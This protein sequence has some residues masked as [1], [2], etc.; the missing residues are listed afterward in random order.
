M[1]SMLAVARRSTVGALAALLAVTPLAAQT[2]AKP[3]VIL[4]VG[5]SFFHGAF[6]PVRSY[7]VAAV[8]DENAG[9]AAGNPRSEGN[10]GPY[11]GIPGIFKKLTDEADLRY[12]VH[13][14]LMS[15]R[16]LEFHYVNALPVIDQPKWDVVVMHDFS[17]GPVPAARTGKPELFVKYADLLEQ[18]VHAANT[19]ADV[20]LYETWSRADLTYPEK[21]PYHGA[22]IEAMGNDLHDAYYRELAHN[23]KIKA[24]AP[25]GD[26][27]LT[28]IYT[29]VAMADPSA[30]R[31]DQDQSSLGTGPRYHPSIYGA[32]L[33]ALVV[34]DQ[35]TGKDARS[36]GASEKAAADLGIAPEMAVTLQ[37]IAHE[38]VHAPVR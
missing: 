30:S 17:T 31:R 5:N 8:T 12:E 2:P 11:G 27:W 6:Q 3:T 22:P 14:E 37:R 33:N 32:Y 28:A 23:P 20:Y 9:I 26:A 34:F 1:P 13:S 25:A 16:S 18:T 19:R 21:G 15:G 29:G 4:F 10:Q 35:I 38:Q 7:N 36:F 24:V